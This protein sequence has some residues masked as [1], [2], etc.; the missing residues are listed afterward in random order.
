MNAPLTTFTAIDFET[1]RG[2][3]WSICQVGLVRVEGGEVVRELSLLIQ[4]PENYY[5]HSFTQIHGLCWEDTCSAPNFAQAWPTLLPWLQDQTVV[6]H[7]AAFDM[8]CLRA[9]LDF[10][11]IEHPQFTQA[12]TYRIFRAGLAQLCS[13]YDIPLNHHDALSDARAC[14]LLFLRS[15]AA[16]GVES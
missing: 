8:S 1:A 4:P 2:P 9:V 13:Q 15:W 16:S 3:R 10:Y 7:N 11:Q 5:W 14:A 12:C 6:A